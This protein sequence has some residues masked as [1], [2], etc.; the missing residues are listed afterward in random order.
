MPDVR[1]R[2]PARLTITIL[3]TLN[4]RMLASRGK[5]SY[6]GAWPEDLALHRPV[7]PRLR[8]RLSSEFIP[9][10][11]FEPQAEIDLAGRRLAVQNTSHGYNGSHGSPLTDIG[12]RDG[13]VGVIQSIHHDQAKLHPGLFS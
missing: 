12:P 2:A 6:H 1:R 10:L 5:L 13:K 3:Y 7:S 4:L 9:T 8:A 11:P